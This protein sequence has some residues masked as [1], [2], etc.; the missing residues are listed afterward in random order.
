MENFTQLTRW[1]QH[2][3]IVQ[4]NQHITTNSP[5]AC[6][7]CK[8]FQI[9]HTHIIQLSFLDFRKT[10]STISAQHYNAVNSTCC[11]NSRHACGICNPFQREHTH[12]IQIAFWTFESL[13]LH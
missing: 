4:S 6:G 3:V 13:F 12:N 5:H 2:H 1:C 9:E 8:L 7:I 10:I 11:Y